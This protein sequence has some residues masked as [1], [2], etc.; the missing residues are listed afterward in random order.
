MLELLAQAARNADPVGFW[1]GSLFAAAVTAFLVRF[2]LDAFWK[3]RLVLD[4]P[5]ARI[6]SAPQGYVELQGQARPQREV[7]TA[8]LSGAACVWYRYRIQERR[9]GTK[10]NGH[11][12]TIEQGDAGRPF[13]LDDG[14]GRCLVDPAGAVLKCRATD[15]WYDSGSGS[16]SGL[17]ALFGQQ[18]RYRKTE[19]RIGELE[20]VYVLGHFETPRRGVRERQR[21]TRHLLSQWKRDPAR[22]Q[23]FD[24]NGDGEIDLDEWDA[25]RAKAE[26]LAERTE[27]RL[28]AEPPLSRVIDGGDARQPF[29]VSTEDERDLISR[30]RLHAFGGTLGGLLIGIG[31]AFVLSARALA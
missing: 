3:L 12:V 4:T 27:G 26:R 14:T 31:L 16:G 24:R 2:G 22:M 25:A 23:V 20:Y 9:R 28:S 11:W 18:R 8:R 7:I 19:E 29:V 5:T 10:N 6:R 1:I 15:V 13:I 17:G 21:L 30:L